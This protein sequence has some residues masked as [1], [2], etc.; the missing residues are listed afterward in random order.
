MDICESSIAELLPHG[1]EMI[2]IDQL[3]SHESSQSVAIVRIRE[4]SRFVDA[5][6]AVPAWIGIEYMAQT[7]AAHVGA[8]A[9]MADE[10]PPVGLLLGTRRYAAA[11]PCFPPGSRLVVT[12]RPQFTEAGF[13]SFLCTIEDDRLLASAELNTYQPSPQRL[14]ELGLA[15]E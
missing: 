8:Q 6:G 14:K 10:K 9:R 2:L 1:P 7:V 5:S 15:V 13:G 12:V 4:N 3:I 11:V